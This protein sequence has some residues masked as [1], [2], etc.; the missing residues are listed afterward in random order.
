LPALAVGLGQSQT[1]FDEEFSVRV[2]VI[3]QVLADPALVGAMSET[4]SRRVVNSDV[5]IAVGEGALGV[6]ECGEGLSFP[7]L[8]MRATAP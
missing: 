5:E 2:L 1:L 4:S 7:T 6:V 3:A 8:L